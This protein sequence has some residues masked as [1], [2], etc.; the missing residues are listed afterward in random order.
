MGG[1]CGKQEYLVLV[2]V[3][4]DHSMARLGGFRKVGFAVGRIN[5]R[6]RIE[7]YLPRVQG[8]SI[9]EWLTGWVLHFLEYSN[10]LVR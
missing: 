6:H 4:A 5:S 8:D 3:C 1:R 9:N 7:M 10:W 2:L